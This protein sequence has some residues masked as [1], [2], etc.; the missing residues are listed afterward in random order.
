MNDVTER[1]RRLTEGR[2]PAALV[3]L[4]A[5]AAW[6][7]LVL[8]FWLLGPEGSPA[9]GLGRLLALAGVILP[10][11]L[12]WMAVGLARAIEELRTEAA[13]LRARMDMLRGSEGEPERPNARPAAEPRPRAEPRPATQARPAAAARA[14]AT[15]PAAPRQSDLPLEPP[16]PPVQAEPATLIIALNFPDGPDDH[17]T[18]SALRTAL[19]DPEAAKVIRAAQDIVTLLAQQGVYTD[20]LRASVASATPWRRLIAGQRGPAL[21]DLAAADA[22][23]AEAIARAMRGDEVFRDAA[24]H[25]M[26]Q[27][28]RTLARSA[29]E[30]GDEGILALAS[31]RSG[32]AFALLAQVMGMF[33]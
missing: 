24:Q 27:F 1:L 15:R 32:R 14:P 7:A 16:P 23:G 29:E 19:A 25:F 20:D 10:L 3:G 5:S 26:R 13:L 28:D 22:D 4:A 17:E 2:D 11:A 8:L 6:V 18:I 12:I 30:L 9:S 21:A 31:T 33:G